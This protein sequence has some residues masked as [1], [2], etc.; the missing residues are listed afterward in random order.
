MVSG[1]E[2]EGV[3]KE[4]DITYSN[5]TLSLPNPHSPSWSGPAGTHQA[6][7]H[8]L[9]HHPYHT[10]LIINYQQSITSLSPTPLTLLVSSGRNPASAALRI[11]ASSR[12]DASDPLTVLV[13]PRLFRALPN[14]LGR[15]NVRESWVS[16]AV[17]AAVTRDAPSPASRVAGVGTRS[18]R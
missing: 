7:P 11:S 5:A 1:D 18:R 8:Q 17:R 14:R 12:S 15:V 6:T 10:S 16:A 4:V 13:I 9:Y 2:G 3:L